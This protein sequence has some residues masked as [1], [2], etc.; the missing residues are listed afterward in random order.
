MNPAMTRALAILTGTLLATGAAQHATSQTGPGW[1][2][3]VDS[4]SMGD[5]DRIGAANWRMDDGAL[6]AD[7]RADKTNAYLVGKTSYT[8]L[9]IYA[10]FWAEANTN[11]G[12]FFR[13]ADRKTIGAKVCYEAN[14]NDPA[15]TNG[16]GALTGISSPNPPVSAGGRWNTFEITARGPQMTIVMN[17]Q[18]TAE[19]K[20]TTYTAGVVALQYIAGTIKWRK[21]AVRPLP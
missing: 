8:N 6:V 12:I 1:V 10:E 19:A 11:S 3:L 16:T 18:K 4:K 13:C 9:Q 14:I 2:T 17:G 5:W 21:V 15:K 20:D 7:G